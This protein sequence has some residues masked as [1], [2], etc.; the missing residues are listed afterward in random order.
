MAAESREKQ[1]DAVAAEPLQ[2]GDRVEVVGTSRMQTTAVLLAY[3]LPFFILIGM[4][5]ILNALID[6]E[7]LVGTL[8]IVSL[9]PY[10]MLLRLFS[11]RISR[12][13]VFIA[14]RSDSSPTSNGKEKC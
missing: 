11:K 8:A 5:F 3:V 2:T 4:V 13:M 12:Q 7:A 1:I 9:L 6:N 10:L 14:K